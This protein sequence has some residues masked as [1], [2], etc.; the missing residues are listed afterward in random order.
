MTGEKPTLTLT[1][2]PEA[3]KIDASNKINTK[4]DIAVDVAV[5]IDGTNVTTDT[6][7]KHTDC[8]GKTCTVP[9]GKEFLLHVKTCQLT[10]AK[11]GGAD[12]EPYV[13]KVKKD[14][15]N[16]TEVTIVGNSS[17]T[18]Y[19]LPVGAYTIEED[20]GWSWRYNADNG[21]SASLTARNSSGTITCTNAKTN[22]YWLNGF[23]A[24]VKNIF[25]IPTRN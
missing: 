25:G 7:F 3:G 9:E 4:Q 11:T 2:T 14:G 8:T 21:S 13:F 23:S 19:E 1:Y 6:T 20:T 15:A 22:D 16:Y 17:V 12:N 5:K 24:V 18:I 10:I